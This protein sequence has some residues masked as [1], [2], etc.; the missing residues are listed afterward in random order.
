MRKRARR[1]GF[2]LPEILVT[3]AVVAVLAAV[4]VPTVTQY[5]NKGDRPASL[6]DID[7]VRDGVT[8]FTADVRK[9]PGDLR[10]LTAV[11]VPNDV[12]VA[13]GFTSDSVAYNATDVG[14]WRGAYFSGTLASGS[15]T[16]NGLAITFGPRIARVSGWLQL[17]VTSHDLCSQLWALDVALDEGVGTPATDATTG[18]LVWNNANCTTGATVLTAAQ[19]AQYRLIPAN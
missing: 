17:I 18:H 1:S 19:R 15:F 6:Q 11:I 9:Y 4:V 8:A 2:T 12:L 16:S 5:I 14:H 10:Q 7:Q 13:N 3:V